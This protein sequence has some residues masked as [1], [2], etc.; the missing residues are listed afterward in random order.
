[1]DTYGSYSID[2]FP[3][4][5]SRRIHTSFPHGRSQEDVQR[6][7]N[8]GYNRTKPELEGRASGL[9]LYFLERPFDC[10]TVSNDKVI[11]MLCSDDHRDNRLPM[12]W[13]S[14]RHIIGF[15]TRLITYFV[16]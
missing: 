11:F 16:L 10:F 2:W 4:L 5:D 8:Q 12:F 6:R 13:S 14:V 3:N 7:W 1:M 15:N 9:V